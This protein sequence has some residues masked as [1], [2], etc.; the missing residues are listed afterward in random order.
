MNVSLVKTSSNS[1]SKPTTTEIVV[2]STIANLLERECS[3]PIA[4]PLRTTPPSSP[5]HLVA[6]TI[7]T[8]KDNV[9]NHPKLSST[10]VLGKVGGSLD[11]IVAS[12][13]ASNSSS[14][15]MAVTTPLP[16]RVVQEGGGGSSSTSSDESS[17]FSS[18]DSSGDEEEDDKERSSVFLSLDPQHLRNE[19]VGGTVDP[20]EQKQLQ[21]QQQQQQH[22]SLKQD[23]R[24]KSF[25]Q[26][27]QESNLQ[28]QQEKKLPQQQEEEEQQEQHHQQ[29][30]HQHQHQ[31]QLEDQ[32]QHQQQLED[33][34]DQ[35]RQRQRQ[36]QR[37]HQ[38]QYQR[39]QQQQ[40]RQQQ[41][42]LH[43][44]EL[45][46]ESQENS[47]QRHQHQQDNLTRNSQ[48][49]Q[50]KVRHSIQPD[51][52]R[53]KLY[54]LNSDGS[55]D[56]CG[57]GRITCVF[58]PT[59][60]K[61]MNKDKLSKEGGTNTSSTES[62]APNNS[63]YDGKQLV[64]TENS[65]NIL[66]DSDITN[67]NKN[68]S[69]NS[70]HENDNNINT[71][72]K[73]S[74]PNPGIP[75]GEGKDLDIIEDELY[76][77]LSEPTL[78]MHAELTSSTNNATTLMSQH[79]YNNS[80][81]DVTQNQADTHPITDSSSNTADKSSSFSASTAISVP[82]V[83]PIA[84]PKVLLRT[85]VL[86]RDVY[87]RQ[88]DNIIT[89]CEP[90]V[91]PPSSEVARPQGNLN[92]SKEKDNNDVEKKHLHDRKDEDDDDHSSHNDNHI[93]T[94]TPSAGV[95][96]ALSFQDNAGCLDIWNKIKNVQRRARD[97]YM[98]KNAIRDEDGVSHLHYRHLVGAT[99]GEGQTEIND[100]KTSEEVDDEID[101]NGHSQQQTGTTDADNYP[102]KEPN[103]GRQRENKSQGVIDWIMDGA[104]ADNASN[105]N[106]IVVENNHQVTI[107]SGEE[108]QSSM[109]V[110]A[111]PLS[112][113]TLPSNTPSGSVLS[114]NGDRQH[115]YVVD[116]SNEH[117]LNEAQ[118]VVV[119]MAAAAAA[120][121]RDGDGLGIGGEGRNGDGIGRGG[122]GKGMLQGM[123]MSGHGGNLP[124][125]GVIGGGIQLPNPPSLANL[126]EIADII[127]AAQVRV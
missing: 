29:Q 4:F 26:L 70:N 64:C 42:H 62:N 6:G 127:A 96:L 108:H 99:I 76:Y 32:Q 44:E 75:E 7:S 122:W 13:V 3:K 25:T 52:W 120:A 117:E 91:F 54:R 58:S 51:G 77:D 79:Q 28:S 40:Q 21:Q 100:C 12:T 82:V 35:H 126:E 95:D 37:Q 81:L 114:V 112:G 73:R 19:N 116:D 74:R 14:T 33:Q 107:S 121:Y 2:S 111:I 41:S 56:D 72:N 61:M 50:Q 113:D 104:N 93:N 23:S 46:Y 92:N 103:N 30:Q 86:L 101:G 80:V 106:G 68:N 67:N 119:S 59:S 55:W 97:L 53:V 124:D 9:Y 123:D 63:R 22:Q 11:I 34:Q 5:S 48:Q 94:N 60:L 10:A 90:S 57:T 45:D 98:K 24:L 84:L 109:C 65:S 31:Q 38:H 66:T 102:H 18:G 118:A 15:S 49:V 39:Q 43:Q 125:G 69:N 8:T 89:W 78:C 110:G 16:F 1:S 20:N 47:S 88:G 27:Q 85:R 71:V 17:S 115:E 83:A 105:N 36:R 87:Q